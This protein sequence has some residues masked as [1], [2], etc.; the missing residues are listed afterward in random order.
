MTQ[1]CPL[2][3]EGL[4]PRSC[5]RRQ[6]ARSSWNS[7]SSLSGSYCD[8]PPNTSMRRPVTTALCPARGSGRK[9]P[10]GMTRRHSSLS[11][12]S[13][14]MSLRNSPP[15]SISSSAIP[16]NSDTPT[17]TQPP[18]TTNSCTGSSC[19]PTLP[20]SSST[21]PWKKRSAPMPPTTRHA[22]CMH[23][24]CG[25]TPVVLGAF[26]TSGSLVTFSTP[27]STC[28]PA[29]QSSPSQPPNS[30][31]RQVLNWYG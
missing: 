12:S 31:I 17:E 16:W 19:A 4:A 15:L 23:R 25:R 3:G 5:T 13:A 6:V 9:V 10:R 29:V 11:M 2:R 21:W 28:S 22:E 20:I 18:N 27:S 1:L 30:I 7:S 14:H 8:C 26:H 24:G